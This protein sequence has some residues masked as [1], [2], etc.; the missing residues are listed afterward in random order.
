MTNLF[1]ALIDRCQAAI[2]SFDTTNPSAVL[3]Q[4]R[5]VIALFPADSDGQERWRLQS[6]LNHIL[7]RFAK[8]AGLDASNEVTRGLADA[9]ALIS[10]FDHWHATVEGC[11]D[12]MEFVA[13]AKVPSFPKA[14]PTAPRC[15]RRALRLI[16]EQYSDPTLTLRSLAKRLDLTIWH[17]AHLLKEHL[18][19]SFTTILR[20]RRVASAQHMLLHSCGSP[21]FRSWC[22]SCRRYASTT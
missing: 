10:R 19:E 17:A 9:S 4:I 12:A 13:M 1:G 22:E 6:V 21:I 11:V 3:A 15:V 20:A 7:A 18:G 5:S 14:K 2:G 8:D 16:D